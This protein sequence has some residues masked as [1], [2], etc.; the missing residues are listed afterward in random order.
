M[1][2]QPLVNGY[3]S[4]T[5]ITTSRQHQTSRSVDMPNEV[6][7]KLPPISQVDCLGLHRVD[8]DAITKER[9]DKMSSLR[10]RHKRISTGPMNEREFGFARRKKKNTDGIDGK[11]PPISQIGMGSEF[12]V[13]WWKTR[14]PKRNIN[15]TRLLPM[16]QVSCLMYSPEKDHP[17]VRKE[18][19]D[20]RAK[21]GVHESDSE[22]V[23]L[24]KAGGQ[25]GLLHYIEA[26][27]P[28]KRT[29]DNKYY[30]GSNG[31]LPELKSKSVQDPTWKPSQWA[32]LSPIRKK[33]HHD[34]SRDS[35]DSN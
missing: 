1:R 25:R 13:P 12:E 9:E 17:Q 24:A 5:H 2:N 20:L 3:N 30:P 35:K 29:L 19:R 10:N 15:A 18:R 11:A 31:S 6:G 32:A 4:P 23:K 27:P 28:L 16:S 7:V 8:V 14:E 33:D 22:Y 34:D 26:K 21:Y